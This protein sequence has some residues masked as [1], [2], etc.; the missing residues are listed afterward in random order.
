MASGLID[1]HA[2]F[3]GTFTTRDPLDGV[4]GLTTVSNPYHYVSN[5]PLNQVDP[6]GLRQT[7]SDLNCS[8]LASR[9][10]V[11]AC[12][13]GSQQSLPACSLQVPLLCAPPPQLSPGPATQCGYHPGNIGDYI[14]GRRQA[15]CG[16]VDDVY[17]PIEVNSYHGNAVVYVGPVT[18]PGN[19]VDGCSAKIGSLIGNG[20]I[21]SY[22]FSSFEVERA[23]REFDVACRAHDYAYDLIRFAW[24]NTHGIRGGALEAQ[25]VGDR[26]DADSEM[27]NINNGVCN[28]TSWSA[29][30]VVW[31]KV[32]CWKLRDLI[33]NGLRLWTLKEGLP[34]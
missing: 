18:G 4:D 10:L 3:Q 23:Y 29:D 24:K 5:D 28:D 14:Y 34:K 8:S 16:F 6:M 27:R 7:D 21:G 9:L 22:L 2:Q 12:T 20:L 32:T 19:T 1:G 11:S 33:Y 30:G 26:K 15:P 31:D 25:L 17:R 13:P